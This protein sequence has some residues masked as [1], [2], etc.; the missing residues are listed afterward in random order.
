M[1]T[2][3][4][5]LFSTKKQFSKK[6]KCP[7]HEIL[8]IGFKSGFWVQELRPKPTSFLIAHMAAERPS[9]GNEWKT[10]GLSIMLLAVWKHSKKLKVQ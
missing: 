3:E 9:V 5:A 1:K 8:K 6:L 10:L 2:T 7:F 4:E